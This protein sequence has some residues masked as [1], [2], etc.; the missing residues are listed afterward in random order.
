[1]QASK[2]TDRLDASWAATGDRIRGFVA[3]RVGDPELAADITQD[4]LV[5]SIASGKLDRVDNPT[6]WLYRSARNAVI[7]HYRTAN[8]TTPSTGPPTAGQIPARRTTDP[9]RPPGSSPAAYSRSSTNSHPR[10]VTPSPGSTSTGR[11]ISKPP[12]NSASRVRDESRVQQPGASSRCCSSAAVRSNSTG[13]APWPPTVPTPTPAVA[14]QIQD[15]DAN[16]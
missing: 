9:T 11:P 7:D 13:T 14:G 2:T 4:V 6:A 1:M 3:S 16:S 5:R 15:R 10:R 8:P 12:T